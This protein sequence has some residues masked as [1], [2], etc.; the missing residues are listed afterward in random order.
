[1]I[2][3]SRISETQIV[4]EY[5]ELLKIYKQLNPNKILE[6]GSLMGFSL[7]HFMKYSSENSTVIS[8]DLPVRDFCG[9]M[10]FRVKEQEENYS[11]KWP[12]WA[13]EFKTKLY[14]I[15]GMSQWNETL[16][17][18]KKI[19]ENELD[20]LFIDGNHMYDYVKKDFEMYSPLVKKGGIVALHDIAENEEGGVF[21][22][23]NEIKTKYNYKEILHSEKK[24]KGI[25]VL[26]I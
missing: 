18:V 7:K 15:K 9:P 23:W 12:L 21:N 14:L 22:F 4:S 1:M 11:I 13:K 2:I 17:Q 6:I 24:E 20:F 5:E 8:V 26:Y 25:G 19:C 10:D 16:E 3:E